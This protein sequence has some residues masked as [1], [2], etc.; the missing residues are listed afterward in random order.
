MP[1]EMCRV[2]IR[3]GCREVDLTLPAHIPLGEMLPATIDL[4]TDDDIDLRAEFAGQTVDLCRVGVP[5]LDPSRSLAQSGV[6][7]GDLLILTTQHIAPPIYRFDPCS[8]I[9][10]VTVAAPASGPPLRTTSVGAGML[11]WAGI[12]EL[13]FLVWLLANGQQSHAVIAGL[14]STVASALAVMVFR[15]NDA[16]RLLSAWSAVWAAA[17]ASVSGALAVPGHLS[18]SHLLLAMS[19]CSTTAFGL[20][21]LLGC[22]TDVLLAVSGSSGLAAVAAFGATLNWWAPVAVG[23]MLVAASLAA[24]PM[25]PR[26]AALVARLSPADVD[27]DKLLQRTT[28]ARGILSLLVTASSG[29]TALGCLLSATCRSGGVAEGGLILAAAIVLLSHIRRHRDPLPAT[30]LAVSGAAAITS[31]LLFAASGD[32]RWAPWLF[33][34]LIPLVLTYVWLA[35]GFAWPGIPFGKQIAEGIEFAMAAAVPSLAC[36]AMGLFSAVRGMSLP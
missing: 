33:S 10:D 26:I 9:R 25:G 35:A 5:P 7:D 31:L 36:W 2:S 15:R 3:A 30:A 1:S 14:V 24:L 20:G 13:C 34:G 8:A 18:A 32:F 23:P 4:V 22:G 19:A 17:F 12:V 16:T 11:C 21:R 28:R 27:D 6:T 29:S